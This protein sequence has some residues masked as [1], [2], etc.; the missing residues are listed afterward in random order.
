MEFESSHLLSFG[1]VTLDGSASYYCEIEYDGDVSEFVRTEVLPSLTAPKISM[2]Q[3]RR[4]IAEFIRAHYDTPPYLMTYVYKY[5]AYHWYKLFGYNDDLTHR[6]IIDFASM[7]FTVGIDP[8]ENSADRRAEFLQSHGVDI[9][10]LRTHNALDD[11]RALRA[12]YR[13]VVLAEQR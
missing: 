13:A 3:A 1:A 11:A 8:E 5:D 2:D 10:T 12:A 9:S 4:E 6:I 7:L